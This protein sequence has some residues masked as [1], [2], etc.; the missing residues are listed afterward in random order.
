[1]ETDNIFEVLSQKIKNNY[2]SEHYATLVD[3]VVKDVFNQNPHCKSY[4]SKYQNYFLDLF[5]TR[6]SPN[7]DLKILKVNFEWILQFLYFLETGIL[8]GSLI[9]TKKFNGFEEVASRHSYNLHPH[10]R[11]ALKN[12]MEGNNYH[13]LTS[14][15]REYD[16]TGKI[17][18]DCFGSIF[19]EIE[20]NEAITTGLTA[21][22]GNIQSSFNGESYWWGSTS[23]PSCLKSSL[24]NDLFL[25]IEAF[26]NANVLF[27][28]TLEIKSAID[29]PWLLARRKIPVNIDP[30]LDQDETFIS[31]NNNLRNFFK[32]DHIPSSYT[33]QPI[34]IPNC[35]KPTTTCYHGNVNINHTT[36]TPVIRLKKLNGGLQ[37]YQPS[38]NQKIKKVGVKVKI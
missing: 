5:S 20:L 1:M 19:K 26:E 28:S 35:P 15:Y 7:L 34:P 38:S 25:P 30:L 12:F 22:Q 31:G 18:Y 17:P 14:Y 16:R 11:E 33:I 36:R 27:N 3:D 13:D 10:Y 23:V 37:Y 6:N 29:L 9:S 32:T 8:S 4:A 24:N 2:D 21:G